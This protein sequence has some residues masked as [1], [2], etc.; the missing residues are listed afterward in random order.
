MPLIATIYTS[1]D[2]SGLAPVLDIT[3]QS[4][5]YQS[6]LSLTEI[7]VEPAVT[8][9]VRYATLLAGALPYNSN[10]PVTA[11]TLFPASILLSINNS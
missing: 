3:I 6:V 9:F 8:L 2:S 4:P 11:K 1:S 5:T 7:V 10:P